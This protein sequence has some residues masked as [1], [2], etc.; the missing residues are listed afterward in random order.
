MKSIEVWKGKLEVA[1]ER[2]RSSEAV[3]GLASAAA[4]ISRIFKLVLKR[5]KFSIMT[6]IVMDFAIKPYQLQIAPNGFFFFFFIS[7][8]ISM[9]S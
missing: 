2:G 6:K 3:T 5:L 9:T 4:T 1:A 7:K 8:F